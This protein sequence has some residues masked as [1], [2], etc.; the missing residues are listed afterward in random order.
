MSILNLLL[1]RFMLN[2]SGMHQLIQKFLR[3]QPIYQ[4]SM[5]GAVV[6][7]AL[8]LLAW[9]IFSNLDFNVQNKAIENKPV[10]V[11]LPT[12]APVP[13]PLAPTQSTQ[14]ATKIP[15]PVATEPE[16]TMVQSASK[17]VASPAASAVSIPKSSF[18]T[19]SPTKTSK[20]QHG[21]RLEGPVQTSTKSVVPPPPATNQ[22]SEIITFTAPLEISGITALE[23]TANAAKSN[24]PAPPRVVAGWQQRQ[25]LYAIAARNKA[26][27]KK[28]LDISETVQPTNTTPSK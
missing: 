22:H 17:P 19:V 25:I 3:L 12:P 18:R 16:K 26:A 28:Q 10:A 8:H 15:T 2:C 5:V 14:Q 13:T 24:Q 9:F 4:L 7:V 23:P 1:K 21:I 20:I 27:R 11:K 6:A